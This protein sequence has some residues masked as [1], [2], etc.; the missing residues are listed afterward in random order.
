MRHCQVLH[1]WIRSLQRGLG[2]N[3]PQAPLTPTFGILEI[4]P[5]SGIL[6][7][8][9]LVRDCWAE[10]TESKMGAF[11]I[12]L[13]G[14]LCL[15]WR[16]FPGKRGAQWA[17]PYFGIRQQSL[18]F[19]RTFRPIRIE[20]CM[21]LQSNNALLCFSPLLGPPFQGAWTI[22]T[23]KSVISLKIFLSKN[24]GPTN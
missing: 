20:F 1:V 12:C 16:L 4:I 5:K 9:L 7:K 2:N 13:D 18:F 3:H 24:T 23:P 19:S 22:S 14:N 21:K 15:A 17:S 6:Y 8:N 11:G 10:S